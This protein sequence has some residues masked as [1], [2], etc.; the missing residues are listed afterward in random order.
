M[1]RPRTTSDEAVL[2]A[3]A[4]A[5][6]RLGPGRLTLGAV[7]EEAGL[8]PAT[9]VQR[10]G[11]KRGLLLALARRAE[12]G[13]RLPF[14]RARRADASPLAA[15]H[16]ALGAMTAG[17]RSTGE[18][19]NNLGFLQLDLTDPQFRAHAAAHARAMGGEI[20]A[21]LEEAVAAGELADGVD[22]ALVARSVHLAYNGALILWAVAGEGDLVDALRADVDAALAPYRA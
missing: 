17:V 1:A 20:A 12:D 14:E 8:A 6:G 7:A 4:R 9:L 15:L 21:L 5:L 16:A 11:S 22:V 18:M 13:A 10:F 19:A 3:A 2:S